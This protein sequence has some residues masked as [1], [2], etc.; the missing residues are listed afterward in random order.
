MQKS[1]KITFFRQI[2][3]GALAWHWSHR[4][5][6]P[7][8]QT[9]TILY[10]M[11]KWFRFGNIKRSNWCNSTAYKHPHHPLLRHHSH[12]LQMPI[13]REKLNRL[14]WFQSQLDPN[15]HRV[16]FAPLCV[17]ISCLSSG[18]MQMQSSGATP[19]AWFLRRDD[20]K[21]LVRVDQWSKKLRAV[22]NDPI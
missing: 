20:K 19:I 21:K 12:R 10:T 4:R 16:H 13:L 5:W 14:R 6:K 9:H 7:D 2:M 22:T 18:Y 8:R 15:M 1:S 3:Y 11:Q 17:N